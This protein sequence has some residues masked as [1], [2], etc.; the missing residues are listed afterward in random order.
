MGLTL[1]LLA[2][3]FAAGIL[4]GWGVG[5]GTLLLLVLTLG[6][7]LEQEAAQG[8]NLLYFLP[9]AAAGLWFHHRRGLLQDAPLGRMV[10]WGLLTAALG[11][12]IATAVDIS[13]LR[14]PLGL[15][16]LWAGISLWRSA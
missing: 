6:L 5:G 16:F 7:H 1:L 9:T 15:L 11:A 13:L 8:I 10:P 2:V 14:R 4:S 3:S 12:A